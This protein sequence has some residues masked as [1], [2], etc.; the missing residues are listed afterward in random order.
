MKKILSS[1]WSGAL[2]SSRAII[3]SGWDDLILPK[4]TCVRGW[5][6][7][8]S[9]TSIHP[10]LEYPHISGNTISDAP[11]V[12]Q[13]WRDHFEKVIMDPL[14]DQMMLVDLGIS[15]GGATAHADDIKTLTSSKECLEKQV[16]ITLRTPVD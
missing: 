10:D 15:T 8:T 2:T 11:S 13:A 3:V 7:A 12:L 14:L 1:A 16:K 5:M 6:T 9:D 4:C